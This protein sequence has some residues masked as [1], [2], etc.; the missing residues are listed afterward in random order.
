MNP[1]TKALLINSV[2]VFAMVIAGTMT[3]DYIKNKMNA[4]AT[5]PA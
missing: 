5:K 4:P 2:V 1:A 3:A